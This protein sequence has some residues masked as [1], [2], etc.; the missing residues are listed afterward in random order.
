V[1][2]NGLVMPTRQQEASSLGWLFNVIF[3]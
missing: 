2:K 3:T 1:L